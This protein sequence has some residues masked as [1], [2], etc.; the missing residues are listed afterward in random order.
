MEK[1]IFYNALSHSYSLSEKEIDVVNELAEKHPYFQAF[2]II[3]LRNTFN[4]TD[5]Y[6]R[7]LD[8]LGIY[9]PDAKYFYKGL[10]LNK[11]YPATEEKK[12]N[13]SLSSENIL[14]DKF[15]IDNKKE[16]L[17]QKEDN[18]LETLQYAPTVYEIEEKEP[19]ITQ[20]EKSEAHNFT[21]WLNSLDNQQEVKQKTPQIEKAVSKIENFVKGKRKIQTN[22]NEEIKNTRKPL[23]TKGSPEQLMSQTLAEIYVKQQLYDKA[24]VIYKRLDLN[25]SEKNTTFA[26]RIKEI[27][28]LKNS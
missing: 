22:T 27:N 10:M 4:D 12:E 15:V 13:R 11:M 17:P 14:A 7:L 8:K 2:Q 19:K 9:I 20:E 26:R 21:E 28:E 24:I 23:Q 18:I 3:K 16:N 1:E 5:K 25:S 6:E